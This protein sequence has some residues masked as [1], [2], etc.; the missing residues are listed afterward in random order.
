M[1]AHSTR[2]L[3]GKTHIAKALGYLATQRGWKML[4]T[5]AADLSLKEVMHRAVAM[6]ML[7][8]VARM[9]RVEPHTRRASRRTS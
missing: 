9:G 5:S 4:F 6:P 7:S 3:T 8:R 1:R 2:K